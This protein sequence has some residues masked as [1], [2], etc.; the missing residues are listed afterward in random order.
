MKI[1]KELDDAKLIIVNL[2]IEVPL[3]KSP[4]CDLTHPAKCRKLTYC[5][6]VG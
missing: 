3:D 6:R 4:S 5:C 1:L 2:N